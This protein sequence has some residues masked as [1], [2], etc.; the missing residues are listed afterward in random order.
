[1]IHSTPVASNAVQRL[2]LLRAWLAQLKEHKVLKLIPLAN[3]A[4]FRHYFRV[5]TDR[6]NLVAMDAPPPLEDC[7]PFVAIAN[8]WR[9]YA[10]NV[11]EILAQNLEMGFLLLTDFGDE[12]LL[13][14]LSPDNAEQ[15]YAK[16][17]QELLLIQQV[18][19][20]AP[21]SFPNYDTA[22]LMQELLFFTEWFLQ[23]HL[24][25]E[26]TN[27]EQATLA[28]TY[29]LLVNSAVSQPQV[30]VHRDY[31]SRNLMLQ[32]QKIGVIDFQDA[33]WGPIS[34]DL[35]SLLRDCYIAWPADKV[36][37]WL[38]DYYYLACEKKFLTNV[39]LEQFKQWFDWMGMQRHLKA[40]FIFARK[41]HR[42]NNANYLTYIPRCLNYVTTVC[43]QYPEFS[44]FHTFI[45][46]RV[47]PNLDI[48][49]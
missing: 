22:Y 45:V 7:Y 40:I 37:K 15:L 44:D 18:K 21:Y 41:L 30:C 27:K 49:L 12:L 10:I 38:Q 46:E 23:K 28:K 43:Q 5:E 20:H 24:F 33:M 13:N 42:D 39:S 14:S 6:G 36:E 34:Y 17:I 35:V 48:T 47:L 11:P 9:S 1:M 16:A 2:E 32:Q 8:A 29:E 19:Q 25:L 3:D 4:S 26:L 31:H